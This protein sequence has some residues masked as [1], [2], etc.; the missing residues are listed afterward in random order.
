MSGVN[1]QIRGPS[2]SPSSAQ[3]EMRCWV[4]I[5]L[6]GI[7]YSS[8]PYPTPQWRMMKTVTEILPGVSASCGEFCI[9][10]ASNP[11]DVKMRDRSTNKTKKRLRLG[12]R[13]NIGL[14]CIGA[15]ILIRKAYIRCSDLTAATGVPCGWSMICHGLTWDL[16]F[17]MTEFSQ[18]QMNI[19]VFLG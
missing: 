15:I 3:E 16:Q 19:S 1:P 13:G 2:A 18:V 10:I 14:T 6:D 17:D 8:R 7:A 12:L 5:Q 4:L 9:D 11:M